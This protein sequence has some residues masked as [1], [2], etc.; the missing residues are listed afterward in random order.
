VG[1]LVIV[2]LPL[3]VFG[4]VLARSSK[5]PGP[6]GRMRRRRVPAEQWTW[7]ENR[8]GG[9]AEAANVLG[10]WPA[11]PPHLLEQWTRR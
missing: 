4:L 11:P 10:R 9:P 7:P 3:A 2:A 8:A 6:D 5:V 1:F